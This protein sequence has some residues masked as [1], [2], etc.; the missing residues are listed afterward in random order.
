MKKYIVLCVALCAAATSLRAQDMIVLRNAKA[1]EIPAKVLE[2][3]ETQIRYRKFSNPDGPVYTI[4]K[5][6]VFFIRY[7]NGEKEVISSYEASPANASSASA[8]SA[9]PAVVYGSSAAQASR[10][11]AA[12][13]QPLR[14][15]SWEIG[16]S[17]TIG[18]GIVL[19]EEDA[20][21]GPSIGAD[22][23]VNY[24]FSRY[25]SDCV[26]A[27]LGFSYNSLGSAD[28]DDFD[29]M[30]MNLDL[31]YG[32]AGSARGS[33]FGYKGGLAFNFPLSCKSPGYDLSE[34][35]NGACFGLFAQVGWTWR[36]SDLAL[37]VQYNVTNTF[38]EIDS[39]FF[40]LGL[41]Y[42]YRF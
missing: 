31:Y 3:G 4:G 18:V 9:S 2:V 21:T 8:R 37:R 23:G 42:G 28:S 10:Y 34:A 39:S 24:Y 30:L 20:W 38:K 17:P 22:V 11:A 7:E 35:L 15:R 1:E 32:S 33:A 16:V 6:E 5:S 12:K 29:L 36:H 14:D 41:V 19:F 27:S 26:G 40:R 25:S 13:R